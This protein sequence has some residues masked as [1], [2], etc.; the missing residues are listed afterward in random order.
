MKY[1]K[2][3]LA[4]G[5]PTVINILLLLIFSCV[6]ML[7]LSHARSD[8]MTSKHSIEISNAYYKADT[9]GQQILDMLSAYSGYAPD[10]A[11][12]EMENIL[13]EQGIAAIY[14]KAS[15]VLSFTLP[16]DEAGTLQ[17]DIHIISSGQF[18]VTKWQLI[19]PES[20]QSS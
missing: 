1:K 3:S 10:T 4:V 6:S 18:E 19:P 11:G 12:H 2:G 8:L 17:I 16:A 5:F 15:Q 20:E 13:N 7:S 9:K 14:E